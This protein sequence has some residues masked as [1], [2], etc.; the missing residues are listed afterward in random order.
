MAIKTCTTG[1]KF[2]TDKVAQQKFPIPPSE[3]LAYAEEA[4]IGGHED[5]LLLG[6]IGVLID[7]QGKDSGASSGSLIRTHRRNHLVAV[8]R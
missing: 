1:K 2:E 4:I 8:P 3:V 5:K 7:D 6:T